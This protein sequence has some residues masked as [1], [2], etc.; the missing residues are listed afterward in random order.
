VSLATFVYIVLA[1]ALLAFGW[2]A[3]ALVLL[4]FWQHFGPGT[5]PGAF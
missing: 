1:M 3:I 2:W 5:V 4:P